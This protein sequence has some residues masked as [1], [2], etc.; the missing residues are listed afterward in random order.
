MELRP[1]RVRRKLE[2]GD[3]AFIVGGFT[4][5]DDIDALGPVGLD[6]IW[7]EGNTAAWTRPISAT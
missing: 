2:A 7:L 6:G 1:N 3:P 4:H 5:A